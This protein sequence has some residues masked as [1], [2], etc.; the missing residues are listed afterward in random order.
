MSIQIIHDQPDSCCIWMPFVQHLLDLRRPIFPGATFRRSNMPFP[1]QGFYL[2]KY[3]GHTVSDIFIINSQRLPRRTGNRFINLSNQL[4]AGFVHTYN[5]IIRIIRQAARFQ[6]ILHRSYKGRALLRQHFP[7]LPDV[8]FKRRFFKILCTVMGDTDGAKLSSTALSAKSLTVHRA[9]PSVAAEHASA[10]SLASNAPSNCASRGGF[11]LGLRS[12]AA[13]SPSSTKRFFIFS[14]ARLVIP[15]ASATSATFHAGPP[16]PASH[17]QCAGMDVSPRFGFT[18]T[19]QL[20]K[21]LPL[22]LR[23]YYAIPCCH[24]SLPPLQRH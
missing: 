18:R 17:K 7:M 12:K 20:V 21:L 3:F 13:V 14:I 1:G 15:R 23:Q 11:S 4:L 6:N 9:R 16:G 2:H 8:R 19:C 24:M 10:I 22:F 5:W